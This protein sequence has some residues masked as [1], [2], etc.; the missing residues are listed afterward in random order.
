MTRRDKCFVLGR[1]LQKTDPDI[2]ARAWKYLGIT[3]ECMQHRDMIKFADIMEAIR[4]AQLDAIKA[5]AR[6]MSQS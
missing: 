6:H 3:L 4:K 5:K 1:R 2:G